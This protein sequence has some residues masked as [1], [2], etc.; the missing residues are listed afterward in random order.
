M[1]FTCLRLTVSS[2]A[3]R[4]RPGTRLCTSKALHSAY[5]AHS[6]SRLLFT[7]TLLHKQWQILFGCGVAS[8][9][10]HYCCCTRYSKWF[11]MADMSVGWLHYRV[12]ET[13][14]YEGCVNRC[15]WS[16]VSLRPPLRRWTASG[17][18]GCDTAERV[19]STTPA[20][21]LHAFNNSFFQFLLLHSYL[22][23]LQA[24]TVYGKYFLWSKI[25]WYNSGFWIHRSRRFHTEFCHL[26]FLMIHFGWIVKCVGLL[27]L[28][29]ILLLLLLSLFGR[30]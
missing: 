14:G 18:R 20:Y 12:S 24:M 9:C 6:N 11:L 3:L 4:I 8:N 19:R 5:S 21:H 29:F 13:G 26:P 22:P 16:H 1:R 17:A 23:P 7:L 30:T 15:L 2:V 25:C 27:C 10:C 28:S